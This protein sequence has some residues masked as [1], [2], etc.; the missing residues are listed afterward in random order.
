MSSSKKNKMIL[1]RRTGIMQ[2]ILLQIHRFLMGTAFLATAS[3]VIM[4]FVEECGTYV[5]VST[6]NI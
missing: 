3:G 6:E 2:A 4:M 1:R 5:K